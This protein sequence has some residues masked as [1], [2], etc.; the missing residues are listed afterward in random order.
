MMFRTMS[1]VHGVLYRRGLARSMGPMQQILLTTTGRKSGQ[2]HTVPLGAVPEGDGWVVIA[3]FNGNDVHPSWWLNLVA[4]PD[5]TIQVN[6]QVIRV[7]MREITD[8]ADRE[9]I[10]KTVVSRLDRYASYSKKTSRVIPLGLL[11]PIA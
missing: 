10:W 11:R 7:R 9:R 8:A 1:A 6:D 5:A 2:S 4:H 3:S